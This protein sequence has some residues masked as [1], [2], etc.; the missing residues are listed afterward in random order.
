[1]KNQVALIQKITYGLIILVFLSSFLPLSETMAARGETRAN[2]FLEENT[3]QATETAVEST[4]VAETPTLTDEPGSILLGSTPPAGYDCT[5]QSQIPQEECNALVALY[6]S[7]AGPNWKNKTG[8]LQTGEPCSWYGL[9]CGSGHVI[10][11]LLE[12]NQLSGAIPPE[13]GSLTSLQDLFLSNNQLSGA[14]P[15][16]IGSLT[17][18]QYL[19]LSNNQLSG[20]IPPE[21]G[22][23]TSLQGLS[24]GGNQLSGAIPP[25][26]GSLTS[27]ISLDLSWNQLSGAIPPEIGNLTSLQVLFLCINQLS[28]AIPPEIG[29]LTSLWN[30]YMND[31]QLSGAIPPEIG[32]LTSLQ[33]LALSDNQL[34]GVI[35]PEIGYLTSLQYLGLSNNQLSGAI[36][37][38]IPSLTSLISLELS[39]NQLSGAIPPEIGYLT[40]LQYLGLYNNQLS[41]AIPPEIGSLTS[42]WYLFLNNNQLRGAIP[43]EIGSLTSLMSLDLSYNQL[44]GTIPPEI[45]YLTSVDYLNIN[46]NCLY[47][48]DMEVIVFLDAKNPGWQSM[49]GGETCGV[50]NHVPTDITLSDNTVADGAPSGTVVGTLT[51]QDEDVGDTHT[52]SLASSAGDTDNASFSIDGDMLKTNVV[53]D[54]GT[55]KSYSIRVQT[56]D[57]L[58]ATFQK[59]FIISVVPAICQTVT[60]I[61]FPECET[62]VLFYHSTGGANWTDHTGWLAT[63]TPCSWYG[64][65]CHDGHVVSLSL[66]GNHLVGEIPKALWKLNNL[67]SLSLGYNT[68]VGKIPDELGLLSNLQ[69]LTLGENGLKG[70]IPSSLGELSNLQTLDLH[71]NHLSREVPAAIGNLSSLQQL[72]LAGNKLIGVI[73][74]EVGN[75]IGLLALDI[76]GNDLLGE[77][78]LAITNLT[79][80]TSTDIGYNHLISTNQMV[81]D[82]LSIKDPDWEST[83]T[84]AD[85]IDVSL[86]NTS[87][88]ESIPVGTV[89]GNFTTTDPD[90]GPNYTYSLVS[91]TGDTDN[92]SFTIDGDKLKTNAVFDYTTKSSY[93]I[94]AQVD[95]GR[96]GVFQKEFTIEITS[97]PGGTTR[98]SI[99]SDGIQGD[100]A[101]GNASIS[102]NGRYVAYEST[103]GNL[104]IGDTNWASDIFVHDRQTGETSR[105]SVASDGTQASG[106]PP[107]MPMP[108]G[109]SNSYRPSISAD[110]R[111]VTFYSYADNLV[112]GDTNGNGDVF[113]HDRQTGETALVSVSSDGTQGIYF[114]TTSSISADGRYV[115]F[116]SWSSNLVSGDMYGFK[117]IF[118][119]DRQTRQTTRVSVSS[120]GTEGNN[121]SWLPS[122]SGDGRY[123]AFGSLASNFVADDTNGAWDVFVHDRQTGETK[124]VSVSTDDTPGNGNSGWEDEDAVFLRTLSLSSDGRYI[125]FVSAAS[126]LVSGDTNGNADVFVYDQQTGETRR[127]SVSSDGAEGSGDSLGV[128]ISEN[129]RYIAFGSNANNLISWD[130]NWGS[131][132]FVHDRLTGKTTIASVSTNDI[133]GQGYA[134]GPSISADGRWIA[135]SSTAANLVDGDTNWQYDVF[136]HENFPGGFSCAIAYGIPQEECEALEKFYNLT[137]GPNWT[138]HTGWLE[139]FEPCQWYGVTCDADHV[140]SLALYGNHLVGKL[141]KVLWKLSFL[142]VLNLGYNSLYGSIPAEFGKLTHLRVLDLS[143]NGLTG[144][145][146]PELGGILGQGFNLSAP[147]KARLVP[148][149]VVS[150]LTN[151]QILD[152]H[153]NNLS[154]VIPSTLGNLTGLQQ[155]NLA[156]NQLSGAIPTEVGNLNALQELN[157]SGN[158]LSSEIPASI[159]NLNYLTI[160]DIGNNHLESHNWDVRNFLVTADPDWQPTQ[161][162]P[163]NTPIDLSL[164]NISMIENQP[165]GTTIGVL[166]TTD[167]DWDDSFVYSLVSGEGDTDN[168]SF[169][170]DVDKLKPSTALDYET[171]NTYS[172]RVQTDDGR[173]GIF[174][175][176]FTIYVTDVNDIPSDL[177]LSNTSVAENQQI[178]AVVGMFATI[179]QD[180]GDTF[181]YS[182]VSGEGDIDNASFIIDNNSL[183]AN[184]VF[185]YEAKSS[186]GIRIQTDDGRG[187]IFEKVITINIINV[188][189]V[190]TSLSLS[191]TNIAENLPA[192]SIVGSFT[193]TDPDIGDTFTYSLVAGVGDDDNASFS[194]D[195]NILQTNA[196]FNYEAKAVYNIRVQ[197]DDGQGDTFQKQFIINVNDMNDTPTD[198][199]LSNSAID[200]H[201]P[202]GTVVGTFTTTDQDIGDTFTYTLVSG[203]GDSD[204]TAFMVDG[205]ILKT[206][207]IFD[208]E[209]KDSFSIRVQTSDGRG[210]MFQKQFVISISDVNDA[211]TDL[212]LS[213][214]VIAE[215]QP[216]GTTI[217]ALTTTDS[218]VGDTFTYS[219]VSGEGDIDNG[220]FAIQNDAL[221]TNAV[222]DYEAKTSYSIRIQADDG[223]GG[224]F[225]KQ[226]I[227]N[228]LDI[229]DTPTDLSL[230]NTSVNEN[231]PG[232][233]I[234]GTFSTTDA[235]VGDTFTYS[236]VFGEG[237]TDNAAFTIDGD[238]LKT[239][240]V[241]NYE[242]KNSYSIRVRTNDGQGGMLE[243]VFIIN[244]ADVNEIPTDISLSNTSITENQSVGSVVGSFNTTDPDIGDVF[245]YNLVT[246]EGDVDNAS[247]TI[248]GDVLKTS[249]VFDYETK[250]SYN[251]RIQ[252]DDGRG[253]IFQKSFTIN[254]INV[255]DA[256]TDLSLS[257]TSIKENLLTGTVIGTFAT[258][259][260]DI[261]D[262]FTYSLVPGEGDIDNV[263]F[264]ID[265]DTLKTNTIFD[266]EVKRIYNLLVQTEDGNG[267]IFQKQFTIK[268]N[269]EVDAGTYDDNDPNIIYTGDWITAT[270]NGMYNNTYH[271]SSS[272]GSTASFTFNGTGVKLIYYMRP[273]YGVMYISIDGIHVA[274][275]HM[276]TGHLQLQ[277][278][279]SSNTLTP[280]M[281]TLTLTQAH[282]RYVDV[283]AIIVVGQ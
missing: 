4:P 125:A 179:D 191:N 22:Y 279:W 66:Y 209:V 140:T 224:M 195:G 35:P 56:D 81:R 19:A 124:R 84:N 69:N 7:T 211:P 201:K 180:A 188:N 33:Y 78:P 113:V 40:S 5:G 246:G 239:K 57:G 105:V 219:L 253:G 88:E 133:Q 117:D 197:T 130:T 17:S 6:N 139:T 108:T 215:N 37:P 26:I 169:V 251:I 107:G 220:F 200:E 27:L 212:N 233:T 234:I 240:G 132:I 265:G 48:N 14:I 42:L 213:N 228:I 229:N 210:G 103:A 162:V 71:S 260:A 227:V 60:E 175:K 79:G 120:D 236:L 257:N 208:K 147:H 243:Q 258:T 223:K 218:D 91:G 230:S 92:V 205:D 99:A 214:A 153:S 199:S 101:S 119:H 237:D 109:N 148:P 82:F 77:I 36:P 112:S 28:G 182:L 245:T 100:S 75:L 165:G 244:I 10:R 274:K 252:I 98:V 73:P 281:H 3:P 167:Y 272:T 217:G 43:P 123:V 59:R 1:M 127:V 90:G 152:L 276:S 283:D 184:E 271:L 247:F 159:V 204:N 161:A 155:L 131:D 135:F 235:D 249:A 259:D 248:D 221:S 134:D 110:G 267:G 94:R 126:N 39:Y 216:I 278:Q 269:D 170:I 136:V 8:W 102:A 145:I 46:N 13:I 277:Q 15:P 256:P 93:S 172:I 142:Q 129:G 21:I 232:G 275:L 80:L 106:G 187:G 146:P 115:A 270:E 137:G 268:I 193:T 192:G 183:K 149:R 68:L 76:S 156:S 25:E 38:E 41:G 118:V 62:L 176:R 168:V 29:G 174:Q 198:L 166:T 189:E 111:Y 122:I 255:N 104:V 11:L 181:T 173:E 45:G 2:I 53:F 154:G 89:V 61:P 266:Y 185:N 158:Q 85:P 263:A 262:T 83:Q 23:L 44:S 20:V 163:N 222:F 95:D 72:N 50:F 86:S 64:V 55:K 164:S 12:E 30:L 171:K 238:M 87:V 231:Q 97:L 151:L 96:G 190:P 74:P 261:G 273:G 24:L 241:F 32:S 160:L 52:Y 282:G 196:I 9:T 242:V 280:G 157:L 203:D 31:N 116:E 16:E 70:N 51:S 63:D 141:P 264:V 54:F 186:Y 67:E 202:A 225:Q 138:N 206:M 207:G 121:N 254:I 226:F 194:T 58:G 34:S 150:S 178:G 49:Q 250:T 143:E 128:A 47:A 114:S 65:T 18:L 177:S 144:E